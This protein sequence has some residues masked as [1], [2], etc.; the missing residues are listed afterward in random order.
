MAERPFLRLGAAT[1]LASISGGVAR[2]EVRR[3]LSAPF[4]GRANSKFLVMHQHETLPHGEQLLDALDAAALDTA[5]VDDLVAGARFAT[6]QYLRM[7]DW[8]LDT[9]CAASLADAPFEMD[10]LDAAGALACGQR[11]RLSSFFT[12]SSRRS[13]THRRPES[14]RLNPKDLFMLERNLP[15]QVSCGIAASDPSGVPP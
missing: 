14:N 6:V 2:D 8:A 13:P 10:A 15:S 3:A 5:L 1:V 7:A 11:G 12:H 4:L 9:T